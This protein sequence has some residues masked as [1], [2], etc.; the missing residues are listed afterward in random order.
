MRQFDVVVIGAGPG[1]YV[2]AIQASRKGLST[3]LIE[4]EAAGGLCLNWGCIPS[5]ILL[6]D[7]VIYTRAQKMLTAGRLEGELKPRFTE[8]VQHSRSRVETIRRGLERLITSSRVTLIS[9][10]VRFE[11]PHTLIISSP[12]S[13]EE[14]VGAIHVVIAT[15]SKPKTLPQL[16]IDGERVITSREA[17]ALKDLPLDLVIVGGGVIGC[18]MATLFAALG[19]KVTILEY[20]PQLLP[21]IDADIG[22]TL[23]KAFTSRGIRVRT[24]TRLTGV[25]KT[26][27]GIRVAIQ[28]SEAQE[29]DLVLVSVGITGAIE[30]LGLEKTGVSTE[31]GFIVVDPATYRTNIPHIFAIGDVAG[32]TD[33]PHPGLAHVASCEGEI[34]AEVIAD[35]KAG[36]QI[37]YDNIPFT[38]FTDPEIGTCGF[39]KEAAIANHPEHRDGIYEQRVEDRVMGIAIALEETLGLTKIIV[40]EACFGK[41]LGAHIIGPAAT[42]RIHVW[43]AARRAG[44]SSRL[45]AHEVMAHPTFSEVFREALLS[46]DGNAVHVPLT[47]QRGA[48]KKKVSP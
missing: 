28:N 19:T 11:D 27:S 5:K 42:E 4:K 45:M 10:T 21:G 6:K 9:G 7:A 12:G 41:I 35:S 34:T 17:L 47:L 30:G 15:G 18:E 31:R 25:E 23:T 2:A 33:R 36:W 38:I 22:K 20:T 40:D 29:A 26:A 44:E 16:P 39:T 43:T 32:F 37:D 14:R 1:G 8:W 48:E 46:L 3:A 13:Q 24:E